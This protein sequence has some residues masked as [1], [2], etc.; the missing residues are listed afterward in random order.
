MDSYYEIL[1]I[2][3]TASSAEIR[4]AYARLARERHPDRFTDPEEKARAHEFFRDLTTAFNTLSNEKSRREYDIESQTPRSAVP[5][6]IARH[7]F[8]TGVARLK[9]RDFHEAVQQ[10]R[11]AVRHMPE[12]PRFH[13]AL[14]SALANNPHWV[15]EAIEAIDNAIRLAPQEPAFHLQLARLLD[16]QGLKLRARKAAE[17]ALRLA[18]GDPGV[19]VGAAELGVGPT[20]EPPP[21]APGGLRGLLR[22]KP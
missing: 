19:I 6:E 2:P 14:A 18:P 15:R 16:G 12:E 1:G 3:K 4:Q 9:A 17:A 5:E 13:A 21:P 8:E 10:F 20:E 11:V 22:R 7:A